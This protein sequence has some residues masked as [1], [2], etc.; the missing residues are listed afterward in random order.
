MHA[1]WTLDLMQQFALIEVIIRCLAHS[2][3]ISF[4]MQLSCIV[5]GSRLQTKVVTYHEFHTHS[6]HSTSRLQWRIMIDQCNLQAFIGYKHVSS[7]LAA[8]PVYKS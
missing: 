7:T 4:I 6:K 1:H 2:L 8:R 3:P 5:K